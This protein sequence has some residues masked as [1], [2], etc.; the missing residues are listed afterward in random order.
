[1]NGL[2]KKCIDNRFP[3]YPY[4]S[5]THTL[6]FKNHIAFTHPSELMTKTFPIH[7][8]GHWK[9]VTYSLLSKP[10]VRWNNCVSLDLPSSLPSFLLLLRSLLASGSGRSRFLLSRGNRVTR[11]G[12]CSWAGSRGGGRTAGDF[13]GV[14][15]KQTPKVFLMLLLVQ[16]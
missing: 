3:I 10:N 4:Y 11:G 15:E 14:T 12:A 5:V 6:T 13:T 9:Q 16:N 1:M 7:P 8:P 2:K